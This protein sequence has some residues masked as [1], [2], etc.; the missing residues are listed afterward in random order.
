MMHYIQNT[1]DG[2]WQNFLL[3]VDTSKNHKE[4]M[5]SERFNWVRN[6]P[7]LLLHLLALLAFFVDFSITALA[8]C[9]ACYFVRMF[10]ITGFYHRYFAH[11]TFKT[12]RTVQFIFALIGNMSAQR[13]ALWWAAHHR[14][15]H[16]YSDTEK[17]LH[18]PKQRGF[19]WSHM[20]WFTCDASFAAP[21]Q[22]IKDWVKFPELVW[23]DRFDAFAPIL[24]IALLFGFGELVG[25]LWP[26]LNASGVQ[27]VVWGFFVSTVL[28]S[29]GTFTI[30]SLGHVWGKRRF[31]TKDDSRNNGFL[32]LITL[33]EGWHNNH[34][35]WSASARQGFYWWEV[36]ITYMLLKAM[37]YVG[38]VWDIKPVPQKVLDEGR[39]R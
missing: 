26:S 28:L 32:A 4:D 37:S 13:G 24:M 33:G 20:G 10:A 3:W 16:Q 23:L 31:D 39:V 34:H 22:R 19:W 30:N 25:Y 9:L 38:L 18:S 2:V 15:H 6:I 7:F 27:W 12:S 36:D 29:H 21:K 17:D 14:A 11:K 35:R 8:L 5:S 1:L